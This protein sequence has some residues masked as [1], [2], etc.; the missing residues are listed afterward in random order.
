[1]EARRQN[2]S[3]RLDTKEFP[4][5]IVQAYEAALREAGLPLAAP[6]PPATAEKKGGGSK[7]LWVVLGAAAVAGGAAIALGGGGSEPTPA[8]TIPQVAGRWVGAGGSDGEIFTAGGCNQQNSVQLDLTQSGGTI[9]GSGD[10]VVL[11]ASCSPGAVGATVRYQVTGTIDTQGNIT[12]RFPNGPYANELWSGNLNGAG[13]RM[14]GTLSGI[15]NLS[16]GTWAVNKQ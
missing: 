16:S 15:P 4:P 14:Q 3:L 9:S 7:T 1:M 8:A 10:F 13:T 11:L 5:R 6:P 12:F 2:P